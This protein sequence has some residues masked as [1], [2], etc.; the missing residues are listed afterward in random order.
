MKLI[1]LALFCA[2]CLSS[3]QMV[4]TNVTKFHRLP[5]VGSG[6]TF[7]ILTTLSGGELESAAYTTQIASALEAHGWRRNPTA[8]DYTVAYRYAIGDGRTQSG[9]MPIM[10]QTGG[11]TTYHSGTFNTYGAGA[12]SFGSVSGTSY[13]PAT[14]GMIGAIPYSQTVYTRTLNLIIFDTKGKSVFEGSCR[15][16]GTKGDIHTVLPSMIKALFKDFPGRS[17]KPKLYRNRLQ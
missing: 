9:V 15:S 5:A 11:G 12:S 7:T 6:E 1:I 3:C 17:G 2:T 10:G 8:A 16:T 14:Y 4:E 13:T